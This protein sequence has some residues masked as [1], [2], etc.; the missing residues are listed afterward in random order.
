MKIRNIFRIGSGLLL[1]LLFVQGASYYL[2]NKSND[3]RME[4]LILRDMK[5]LMN[6]EELYAL[7]LQ[8][9]Q[10]V[11]NI[12]IDA[13]DKTAR[14]NLAN[15]EKDFQAVSETVYAM[16]AV[17]AQ[18]DLAALSRRWM[19]LVAVHASAI[20]LA[21]KGE[22]GEAVA[23]LK[24]KGTPLWREIKTQLLAGI[25]QRQE[26]GKA[27]LAAYQAE[28]T[29][30][31]VLYYA[32]TGVFAVFLA[33]AVGFVLRRIIWPILGVSD[34]ARSYAA[35]DFTRQTRIRRRDEIGQ[36][37][38]SMDA[39]GGKVVDVVARIQEASDSVADGAAHIAAAAQD[40]S[41]GVTRQAAM[42]EEI[43]AS[44][45]QIVHSIE[46]NAANAGETQ[47]IAVKAARDAQHGGE[48][49]RRAVGAMQDISEKILI[50]EELA[51][52]TNLLALNAAIEAARAGEHG[53]GFA[54]VA[55]EVRK[56]AEHSGGA[57]VEISTLS[58]STAHIATQAGDML[59]AM[60][61]DIRKNAELVQEMAASSEEQNAGS[62]QVNKAIQ[63]FDQIVQQNA[64][65]SEKL[66]S[67][68]EELS[69]QAG[70]LRQAIAFF[71]IG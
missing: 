52:Q 22:S 7:G 30:Y 27:G 63:Q 40:L 29:S 41:R 56:L 13:Q 26:A 16:A 5:D 57:A 2:Q 6:R 11:R 64:T 18:K 12:L 19:E 45:T 14:T 15:A 66:A 8:C 9:G 46:S 53:K 25:A 37:A 17:E 34:C 62:Q 10:A 54:V 28:M 36:L 33:V 49:V 50:V 20:A 70:Q 61:P 23:I 1:L 47:T 58:S 69:G 3:V 59:D 32:I 42:I 48:A 4:S 55:A 51:R 43:S 31:R 24:S 67:T 39:V 35:G 68:S 44:M 38:A 60:V 71:R 21:D 65:A